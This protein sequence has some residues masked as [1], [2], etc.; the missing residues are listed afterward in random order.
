MSQ[1]DPFRM[2]GSSWL[3]VAAGIG[4]G[5]A[6]TSDTANVTCTTGGWYS[7]LSTGRAP[8]AGTVGAVSGA[9]SDLSVSPASARGSC[10]ASVVQGALG[11][12]TS[13]GGLTCA[14]K[15]KYQRHT[16]GPLFETVASTFIRDGG[17][18]L[19][20]GIAPTGAIPGTEG[21]SLVPAIGLSALE[22][23]DT[24]AESALSSDAVT[25]FLGQ[26]PLNPV[27]YPL[28]NWG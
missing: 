21:A 6:A 28:F 3:N 13:R 20:D 12:S 18:D 15:Y 4:S 10:P 26:K 19:L 22:A 5:T 23:F 11:G 8:M 16:W 9:K 17:A 27:F 14:S 1:I 25:I 24:V 7:Q 2:S